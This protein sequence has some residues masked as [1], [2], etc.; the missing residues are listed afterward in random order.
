MSAAVDTPQ[1]Q[2]EAPSGKPAQPTKPR[3]PVLGVTLYERVTSF[4]MTMILILGVFTFGFG[5]VWAS[6]QKWH[7]LTPKPPPKVDFVEIPD[8]EGGGEETGELDSSL[9]VPGPEGPDVST[10]STAD[11]VSTDAPA[12]EQT[13]TAVLSAVGAAV[14]MADQLM[15]GSDL[16]TSALPSGSKGTGTKRNLGKGPGDGGGVKRQERWEISFEQG[17]TEKEYAQQL[18]YFGIELGA[19]VNGRLYLASNLA[20]EKPAVRDVANPNLE[21][22]LYF[23]WRGGSRR[24]ADVNLLKKAGV[25]VGSG[26]VIVL[27]FYPTDTEQ[28]L[29]RLELNEAQ[30]GGK[31]FKDGKLRMELVRKTKFTVVKEGNGYTFKINKIEYFG[32]APSR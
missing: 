6:N 14:E 23:S 19:I 3:E 1:A 18:D 32:D 12:V 17:Q 29:A 27:Q 26:N 13:M 8:V 11:D 24:Q 2:A 22:R 9:Y 16:N 30:A 31:A 21:K 10:A 7:W 5:A 25:A 15:V 28:R 4:L 20:R